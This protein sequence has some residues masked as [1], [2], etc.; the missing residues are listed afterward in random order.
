MHNF[1]KSG[2]IDLNKETSVW[3][4]NDVFNGL[5]SNKKIML[6][7][8]KGEKVFESK[9]KTIIKAILNDTSIIVIPVLYVT[10]EN[11]D[12]ILWIHN[13]KDNP[14]IL[15][16]NLSF[17]IEL[18]E[19]HTSL[20]KEIDFRKIP[21]KLINDTAAKILLK[22]M[23]GSCYLNKDETLLYDNKIY[24]H[25]TFLCQQEGLKVSTE[26]D[27]IISLQIYNLHIDDKNKWSKYEGKLPFKLDFDLTKEEI[28]KLL[29]KADEENLEKTLCK[30]SKQ[31]LIIK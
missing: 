30:Y 25:K 29:G 19:I 9:E 6:N 22:K 21:G 11:E 7:T 26:N 31:K 27:T 4:S 17:N 3:V 1:F 23:I 24:N 5:K 12:E 15:K 10:T 13:N 28:E 18:K 14:I 8:G 16:M 20:I 2:D